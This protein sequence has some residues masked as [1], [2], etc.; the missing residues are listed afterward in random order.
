ME[1]DTY[2]IRVYQREGFRK[3]SFFINYI[4]GEFLENTVRVL[5][6]NVNKVRRYNRYK[7]YGLGNG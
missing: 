2:R 3:Y 5:P 1:D 6:D 4:D 7:I